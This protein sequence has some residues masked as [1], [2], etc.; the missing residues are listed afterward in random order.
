MNG[1]NANIVIDECAILR[2]Y[3]EARLKLD[4]PL[5]KAFPYLSEP[6]TK[7]GSHFADPMR[8][9]HAALRWVWLGVHE[10]LPAGR[11]QSVV[12]SVVERSIQAAHRAGGNYLRPDHDV[13]L[14]MLS[15]IGGDLATM[16][17]VASAVLPADPLVTEY[18]FLQAWTGILRSRVLQNAD[19]ERGQLDVLKRKRGS[20]VYSCPSQAMA[21]AFVSREYK[22]LNKQI[23][24]AFR[25]ETDALIKDGSIVKN[26]AGQTVVVIRGRNPN[27]YWLW[28]AAVFAKLAYL[29]DGDIECDAL[30]F[31]AQLL[32]LGQSS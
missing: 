30:W 32:E 24:R 13:F 8:V 15:V 12:G 18:Q 6:V 16:R 21:E 27:R 11:I 17:S 5:E 20:T 7:V 10:G 29:G 3:E 4:E 28:S 9:V 23:K 22:L 25:T 2:K 14:M 1:P 26:N 31:P 19:E